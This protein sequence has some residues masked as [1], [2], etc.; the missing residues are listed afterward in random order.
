MFGIRFSTWVKSGIIFVS[1]DKFK[2]N[3]V[4]LQ[5]AFKDECVCPPPPE[6]EHEDENGNFGL[7][8]QT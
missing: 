5:M 3:F 6:D 8:K 1:K 7:L 2:A 4:I